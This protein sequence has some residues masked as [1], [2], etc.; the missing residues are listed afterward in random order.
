MDERDDQLQMISSDIG[1]VESLPEPTRE[2]PQERMARLRTAARSNGHVRTLIDDGQAPTMT[3]R[4]RGGGRGGWSRTWII[5][6]SVASA[7]ALAGV[8]IAA[9]SSGGGSAPAGTPGA[10]SATATQPS[11]GSLLPGAPTARPSST[12][13]SSD[14]ATTSATQ[15]ASVN[16]EGAVAESSLRDIPPLFGPPLRIPARTRVR[17]AE[18]FGAPRSPGFVHAGVDLVALGGGGFDIYSGCTGRV[19]G[20][21]KLDGYGQFV[22]IECD[23][24]VRTV[25]ARLDQVNVKAGESVTSGVTRLGRVTASLHF[26]VRWGGI[27]IDPA[28]YI[29]FAVDPNVTPT[30]QPTDPPAPSVTPSP[31]DP[32]ATATPSGGGPATSTPVPGA[33]TAVPTA[34]PLTPTSTPTVTPTKTPKPPTP[35]PTARPIVR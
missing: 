27:P 19:A 18:A 16:N 7:L 8:A 9:L 32:S 4:R 1:D 34:T 12:A 10:A 2:D 5:A 30:P 17:V 11:A 14:T 6:G 15:E 13:T 26:E 29:D 3:E 21:D 28:K 25:Y 20:A 33:P 22:V 35:T 23:K 31:G 24:D